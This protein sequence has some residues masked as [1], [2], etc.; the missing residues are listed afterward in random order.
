MKDPQ[1]FREDLEW[2]LSR[3]VR[4]SPGHAAWN[5][6]FVKD[7]RRLLNTIDRQF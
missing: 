6:F 7:A 4:Q 1:R 2:V 5:A 3:D